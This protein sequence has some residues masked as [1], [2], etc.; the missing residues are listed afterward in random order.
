M[1]GLKNPIGDPQI[2]GFSVEIE[3]SHPIFWFQWR[4]KSVTVAITTFALW[5]AS[6]IFYPIGGKEQ[7]TEPVNT[8]FLHLAPDETST[9]EFWLAPSHTACDFY[10][11]AG[12]GDSRALWDLLT[13]FM[14][15]LI[16]FLTA[17]VRYPFKS[18]E[19][20]WFIVVKPWFF[21]IWHCLLKFGWMHCWSWKWCMW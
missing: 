3:E 19:S 8:C 10:S 4:G 14:T 20:V 1:A 11:I 13:T 21:R 18:L 17:W 16:E 6:L 2:E 7:L 12:K 5:L 15:L 9:F